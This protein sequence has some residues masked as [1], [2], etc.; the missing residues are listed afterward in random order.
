METFNNKY[1]IASARAPWW[2]YGSNAAYFITICTHGRVHFF[3]EIASDQ[4]ILSEMGVHAQSCWYE[5]PNHFPFVQ[6]GAFVVMPNHIH[7]IIII[8]KPGVLNQESVETQNF[9]SL[10]Q[11]T[12]RQFQTPSLNKFGPQSQNLASIVRG[13][14]IG[15]TKNSKIINPD[16][17][18]QSRYHDHIIRDDAEYQRI[19]DYIE[20][21]PANWNDDK[22]FKQE[23]S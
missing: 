12:S 9:A 6:L 1:R 23:S 7:G 17:K 4:M 19:N 10:P 14:K 13:Y 20:N 22:F 18:W 3:G 21:N 2:D 15:V 8:D 11:R 5:I 16:F